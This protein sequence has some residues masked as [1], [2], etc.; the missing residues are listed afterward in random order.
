MIG[1]H[2]LHVMADPWEI[3]GVWEIFIPEITEGTLYKYRI[4]AHDNSY[5]EKTDP[6]GFHAELSPRTASLVCDLD[7]YKWKDQDW[8]KKQS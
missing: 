6:H 7:K 8:M 5:G 1:T 3:P 4:T 2:R